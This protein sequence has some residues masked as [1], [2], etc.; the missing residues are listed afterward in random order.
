[1]KCIEFVHVFVVIW[2]IKFKMCAVFEFLRPPPEQCLTFK[3]LSPKR[4]EIILTQYVM[5]GENL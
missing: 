5:N 2:K 1:M 3:M 4:L